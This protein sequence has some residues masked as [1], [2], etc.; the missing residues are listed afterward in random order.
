MVDSKELTDK[1]PPPG[2]DEALPSVDPSHYSLETLE[3]GKCL[4]TKL[5]LNFNPT[6]YYLIK[7]YFWREYLPPSIKA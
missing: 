1:K 2:P 3:S 6:T 5:I 7:L 4:F